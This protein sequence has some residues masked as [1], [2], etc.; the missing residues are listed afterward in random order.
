M[1]KPIYDFEKR[2]NK[3]YKISW[4]LFAIAA[5]IA[6]YLIHTKKESVILIII[7][8]SLAIVSRTLYRMTE[9][10][11]ANSFRLRKWEMDYFLLEKLKSLLKKSKEN[12]E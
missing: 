4:I 12:K 5:I 3:K 7:A 1:E 8:G 6:A 2:A 9:E 11:I 10:D